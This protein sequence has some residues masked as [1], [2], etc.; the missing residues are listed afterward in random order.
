MLCELPNKLAEGVGNEDVLLKDD[1]TA[2]E[3]TVGN[4]EPKAGIGVTG[5]FDVCVVSEIKLNE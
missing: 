5:A 4:V 3:D 1:C 2:D